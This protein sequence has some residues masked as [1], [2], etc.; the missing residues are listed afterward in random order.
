MTTRWTLA[1]A[2]GALALG[3]CTS[4]PETG[5]YRAPLCASDGSCA[6]GA[7]CV[8][9]LCH[10]VCA[11]D[12]DCAAGAAC[13]DGVCWASAAGVCASDADCAMSEVCA[14]GTCVAPPAPW[15]CSADEGCPMG[16][17]C[18]GGSCT[19]RGP[20]VCGNGLDDDGDGLIDEDCATA[21]AADSDCA[22][23]GELCVRGI[24][25][26]SGAA[27]VCGNGLDDDGDGMIDEGCGAP[28][29]TDADCSMGEICTGGMCQSR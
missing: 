8:D 16:A 15:T 22:M 12:A 19:A 9:G 1:M 17:A 5:G 28:C 11:T 29:R 25:Q 2:L 26:P 3:G 13:R 27:E 18:V 4:T 20:E 10:D 6:S 14:A 7:R 23:M 21:C 24:C